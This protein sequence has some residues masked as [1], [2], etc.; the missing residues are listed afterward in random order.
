MEETGLRAPPLERHL[1]RLDGEV[2]V[3]HG[4]D[5]PA[6]DKPGEEIQNRHE[7]QLAAG[8]DDELRGIADSAL[9]GP[10]R[11]EGLLEELVGDRLV[12][13]ADRRVFVPLPYW[14]L[15]PSSRISRTTRL[16]LT[17][18]C[19]SIKSSWTRGLP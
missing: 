3:I 7:V 5:R 14:A 15:R 9:I 4:T 17:R 13:I 16:R 8:P 11:V 18:A 1:E 6:H 2:P 19:C 12:V 10:V